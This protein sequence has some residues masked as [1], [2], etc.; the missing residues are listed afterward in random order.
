MTTD[1]AFG[2]IGPTID[3]LIRQ[4]DE[5]TAIEV[6]Q[7][8]ISLARQSDT[9]EVPLSFLSNKDALAR[10]FAQFGDYARDKLQELFDYYR[11]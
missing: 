10:K 7:T 8:V 3:I 2:S 1:Q 6:L 5:S 4:S 9:T 11:T